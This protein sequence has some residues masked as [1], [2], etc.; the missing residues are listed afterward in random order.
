MARTFLQLVNDVLRDLREE[1]VSTWDQTAY[2]K[3]IGG[4]V[5]ALKRDVEAAWLWTPLRQD[6][7]ITTVGGTHTY[8]LTGT[9]ERALILDAWNDTKQWRLREVVGGYVKEYDYGVTPSQASPSEFK[10]AGLNS[11]VRQVRVFPTPSGAEQLYFSCYVPQADLAVDNDAVV[12][13]HRPIVEGAV[14]RARYE[15]GEDGG[16]PF[17][18]QAAFMSRALADAIAIDSA[19]VSEE[20]DWVP[21]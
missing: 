4:F 5:N 1:E 20:L 11:G 13:P 18:G 15:R 14:A 2:S 19:A 7:A 9:D 10:L 16:V 8:D 3:M 12:I 6:I 17:E 21:T